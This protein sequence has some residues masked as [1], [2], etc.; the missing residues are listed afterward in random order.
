M[1]YYTYYELSADPFDGKTPISEEVY[2]ALDA[3]IESMGMSFDH[4]SIS[5][6][7]LY[8]TWYDWEFDMALLSSKFP[9]ILFA[10]HGDGESSDDQWIAYF[11]HGRMQLCQAKIVYPEYDPQKF[12]DHDLPNGYSRGVR[13]GGSA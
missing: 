3:E 9:E 12:E 2:D 7:S 6:R 13:S 1:G 11:N 10:L 8:S 5:E 4:Y